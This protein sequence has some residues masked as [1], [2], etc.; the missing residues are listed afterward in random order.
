MRKGRR[1]TGAVAL[2]FDDGI[3]RRACARIANVLREHDVVGTFFING[4]WLQKAPNQ[5]R[6]IL[7]GMEVANHTR[8]HRDLTR[9]PHPVVKNQ[10]RTNQWIHEQV[11]GRPMLKVLRPPYG[12][13][14]ERVG[15]I[16]AALGYET[17]AMWNV[18]TGDWRPS[19]KPGTVTR[20]AIGGPPGSIILM[21]CSRDATVKALP[22]II[23]HYRGRGIDIEPLSVVLE[24][25]RGVEEG[26]GSQRY[27]N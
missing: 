10:I 25:A 19:S 6:H 16:A 21:H 9:E 17:I 24:G 13:Y 1:A 27:G 22:R 15:R 18:D 23:K 5:W 12:A 7:E 20:R 8:S 2:T 4:Q 3:N 14:G 26:S 11:L